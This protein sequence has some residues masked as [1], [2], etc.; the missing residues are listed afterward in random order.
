MGCVSS[1]ECSPPSTAGWCFHLPSLKPCISSSSQHARRHDPDE[2]IESRHVVSLTSSSYGLLNTERS[3]SQ[4]SFLSFQGQA[5][6]FQALQAAY[7]DSVF[8]PGLDAKHLAACALMQPLKK[9][10][11]EDSLLLSAVTCN[12]H[13]METINTWE[14]MDGLEEGGRNAHL[15][16]TAGYGDSKLRMLKRAGSL[17]LIPTHVTSGLHIASCE[18]PRMP[19]AT[20]PLLS[21]L[22]SPVWTKYYKQSEIP[23]VKE[24]LHLCQDSPLRAPSSPF[25]RSPRRTLSCNHFTDS[26]RK[27]SSCSSLFELEDSKSTSSGDLLD[28]SSSTGLKL[29]LSP[30]NSPSYYVSRLAKKGRFRV[31]SLSFDSKTLRLQKISVDGSSGSPGARRKWSRQ[32]SMDSLKGSDIQLFDPALIATFEQAV[33]AT[34]QFPQDD[35]LQQSMDENTTNSS[36]SDNTWPLS[37]MASDAE[38]GPQLHKQDKLPCATASVK[39]EEK[40]AAV[41]LHWYELRC[42]PQG[43]DKVVLYY[44]SLRGVRK[45]YEDCCTVRLILKGLGVHVDERDVWMH[46]KY[47]EE[48]RDLLGDMVKGVT[49]VPQLFIKGRYIGGAEEVKKLHEDGKLARFMD[50]ISMG[51][52]HN[53]CDGCGDVRF[54]PCLNCNGS[55]K[56]RNHYDEVLRCP[57]C[58]ENG[59]IMCP[60]CSM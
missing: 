20:D 9:K 12:S 18:S 44:T 8:F 15:S 28:S 32:Q 16:S 47:K 31:A 37:E 43:I 13:A 41:L 40:D 1:K 27:P 3:P 57:V 2:D 5:G 25:D 46:S 33:E 35:W 53:V 29:L 7:N 60:I 21:D 10:D 26:I 54:V 19:Y 11:E 42:P 51:M 4:G 14:L 58:N 6:K 49:L 48:L 59:L 56:V 36:S 22:G 50:G 45:T 55:C 39:E 17:D 34:S 52:C 23:M 30:V 24:S 38:S